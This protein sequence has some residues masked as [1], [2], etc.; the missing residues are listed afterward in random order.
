M[1]SAENRVSDDRS[2]RLL[3]WRCIRA[4]GDTL[5]DPL[6]WASFIEVVL[7]LPYDPAEVTLIE[8]EEEVQAFSPQAAQES[9][10]DGI[11]LGSLKGSGQDFDI[12]SISDPVEG[13]AELVVVVANQEARALAER[14]C[15]S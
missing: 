2:R 11:S 8:D 3:Q 6:V 10:A 14:R 13:I 4:A 5:V 12:G 9:L 1:Q 15:F 7:V